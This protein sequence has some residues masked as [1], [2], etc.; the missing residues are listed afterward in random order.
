MPKGEC[1]TSFTTAI[2]TTAVTLQFASPGMVVSQM[3]V[4]SQEES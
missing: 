2:S 4:L 1:S 3:D